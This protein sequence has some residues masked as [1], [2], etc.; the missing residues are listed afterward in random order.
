MGTWKFWNPA[1]L[2][3]LKCWNKKLMTLDWTITSSTPTNCQ[4]CGVQWCLLPT[5]IKYNKLATLWPL[6]RFPFF[7]LSSTTAKTAWQTDFH[8]VYLQAPTTSSG[9]DPVG[10]WAPHFLAVWGSKCTDPHFL[11]PCCSRWLVI[12]SISSAD[13]GMHADFCIMVVH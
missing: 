12:H 8:A 10:S 2:K 6:I 11:V 5:L 9:G 7:F 3:P 1:D 4:F 13:S